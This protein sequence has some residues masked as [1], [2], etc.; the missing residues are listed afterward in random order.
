ML[1][2]GNVCV[3]ILNWNNAFLKCSGRISVYFSFIYIYI[4][5]EKERE[6]ARERKERERYSV[7]ESE[8]ERERE[9]ERERDMIT[10]PYGLAMNY[11]NL[12]V[13]SRF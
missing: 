12:T 6:R 7:R 9:G 13:D 1:L 8:R 3:P 5:R 10:H 11:Y 2:T 4:V